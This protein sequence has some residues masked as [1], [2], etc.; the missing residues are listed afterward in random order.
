MEHVISMRWLVH[1]NR[2]RSHFPYDFW[3]SYEY[4]I[5]YQSEDSCA[6]QSV[7]MLTIE[8]RMVIIF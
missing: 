4:P 1:S 3:S 6:H 8:L 7:V 5:H 2:G